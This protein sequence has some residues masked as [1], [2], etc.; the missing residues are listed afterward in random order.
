MQAL[1][2]RNKGILT[3]VLMVLVLLL[4]FYGLH[5]PVIGTTEYI[6][7]AV[8]IAGI[9]WSLFDFKKTAA[10]DAKFKDYFSTGF[11][12][13]IVVVLIMAVFTFIF[14]K[15]NLQL[16]DGPIEENSKLLLQEGNKTVAE[17]EANAEQ[18]KKIFMPMMVGITT[19]KY[20]AI[21]ALIAAVGAG[22]L[23]QKKE[24]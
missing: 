18:L 13:F 14:Y 2:P 20:L 3:G 15:F 4:F 6:V 16:R 22:F 17:I 10:D 21:G 11:K 8:Y 5:K 1:T 9:L 7:Y 24:Y 23:S 12:T 19:F